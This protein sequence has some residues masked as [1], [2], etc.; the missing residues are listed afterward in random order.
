MFLWK[1]K[2]KNSRKLEDLTS[3]ARKYLTEKIDGETGGGTDDG[4]R[5]ARGYLRPD[6]IKYSSRGDYYNRDTIRSAVRSLS[7]ADSYESVLS[8]L[9]SNTNL[10]FVDKLL[11]HVSRKHLRD[12]EVYKAAQVDRRLFSKIVSDRTYKPAKDTCIALCLALKLT[13][14]EASDLLSRAGYVFSH[15]S[16]RDVVLEY[17]FREGIYDLDD[18]N[19][20][21][22]RLD[23]KV[24]GR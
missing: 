17:F 12:P 11:E 9:E 14:D 5:F 24:L 8:M 10:S 1:K 23:Q 15:S 13:L 2:R 4:P 16:E 7:S 18:V 19:E 3:A 6:E 21:L 20:V 22:F